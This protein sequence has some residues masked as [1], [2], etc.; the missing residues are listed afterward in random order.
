MDIE[1]ASPA[2][3]PPAAE[4]PAAAPGALQCFEH[5]RRP[6]ITRCSSCGRPVCTLCAFE[7]GNWDYCGDCV[8]EQSKSRLE[9]QLCSECGRSNAAESTACVCGHPLLPVTPVAAAAVR[10]K[11]LDERCANHP[12][13]E[14]LVRCGLCARPLCATCDFALP[15]GTHVCPA[16]VE[17]QSTSEPSAKRKSLSHLALGLAVWSTL[18]V[19]MLFLGFFKTLLEGEGSEAADVGITA[20]T[21]WPAVIGLGLALASREKRLKNTA[22]MQAA[23]WWNGAIVVIFLLLIIVNNL[24]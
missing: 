1:G 17:A 18:F 20:I 11:M 14:A 13:S 6:A 9:P 4:S 8:A 21:F 2:T 7:L 5:P 15:G 16:C 19:G 3:S 24:S 12:E 10:R 23:L 22:L